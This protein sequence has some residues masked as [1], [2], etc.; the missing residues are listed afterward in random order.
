MKWIFIICITL[1]ILF[2]VKA[3]VDREYVKGFKSGFV[4][5]CVRAEKGYDECTDLLTFT[6][7][8]V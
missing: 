1:T 7:A 2:Q 5:G 4:T 8:G 3:Y 6:F